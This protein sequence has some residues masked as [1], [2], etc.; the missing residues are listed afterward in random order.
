MYP[1]NDNPDELHKDLSERH[2]KELNPDQKGKQVNQEDDLG[3]WN[4]NSRNDTDPSPSP[5]ANP[6]D[7]PMD[8]ERPAH[9]T[10]NEHPDK[11]SEEGAG[12]RFPSPD[13]ARPD[14]FPDEAQHPGKENPTELRP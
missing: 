14:T 8:P 9:I 7:V 11:S 12:I 10:P 2:E 5:Q 1:N 6:T 4:R 13:E 3:N